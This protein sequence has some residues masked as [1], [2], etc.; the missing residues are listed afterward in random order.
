MTVPVNEPAGKKPLPV[1]EPFTMLPLPGV[2][3]TVPRVGL[4]QIPMKTPPPPPA[5][6][7]DPDSGKAL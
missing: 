4:F 1:K 7:F 3:V 5:V 6:A 2:M